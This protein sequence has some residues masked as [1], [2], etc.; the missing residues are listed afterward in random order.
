VDAEASLVEYLKS[1]AGGK[2]M[3]SPKQLALELPVSE[4]QQSVLRKQQAFPI[5]SQEIGGKIFYSVYDVAAFIVRGKVTNAAGH[6]ESTVRQQA[7]TPKPQKRGAKTQPIADMSHLFN[8][9]SFVAHVQ[10]EAESLTHFADFMTQYERSYS[11]KQKLDA[12]M[13]NKPRRSSAED[14]LGKM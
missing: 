10:H 13:T 14:N 1:K 7:D 6:S 3:M 12:E 11:L 5:G 8:L 4:K 9:R 2:L